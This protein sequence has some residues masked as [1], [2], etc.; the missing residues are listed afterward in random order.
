MVSRQ[1][2]GHHI[3]LDFIGIH[4]RHLIAR[5]GTGVPIR[6]IIQ[7]CIGTA[8]T[9]MI[10]GIAAHG[11]GGMTLGIGD[12]R[13]ITGVGTMTHGTMTRGIVLDTII[14][15]ES[16]ALEEA[17]TIGGTGRRQME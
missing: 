2:T 4:G 9:G 10:H 5:R 1:D 12:V 6:G 11:S 15:M 8:G 14:S 16:L 17:A 7:E 13:H 3:G